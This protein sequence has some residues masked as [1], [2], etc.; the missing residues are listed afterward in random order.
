V[1]QTIFSVLL[2]VVCISCSEDNTESGS[3][4][5]K[6]ASALEPLRDTTT[7]YIYLTFDDG[8][9]DGSED[10]DDAVTK[11]NIKINVF[12]VGQHAQS[13]KK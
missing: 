4:V 7:R 13:T 8:P 2:F 6:K 1:K 3:P 5:N 10:I 11:E 9:L 12:I